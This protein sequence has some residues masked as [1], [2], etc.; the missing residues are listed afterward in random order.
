MRLAKVRMTLLHYCLILHEEGNRHT[1]E[2]RNPRDAM[3]RLSPECALGFTGP[4]EEW[5]ERRVTPQLNADPSINQSVDN[6]DGYR[7]AQS[8]LRG[9]R[10]GFRALWQR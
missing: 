5:L 7:R 9:I 4:F 10:F 6:C 2:R 1:R 8:I 3:S